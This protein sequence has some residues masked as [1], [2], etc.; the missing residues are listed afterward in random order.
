MK[1]ILLIAG[2]EETF[3]KTKE[4]LRQHNYEISIAY[5]LEDAYLLMRTNVYHLVIADD[6]VTGGDSKM[7]LQKI[8]HYQHL[9]IIIITDTN[10]VQSAIDIIKLGAFDYMV[11]PVLPD[12]ILAIIEDA[13]NNNNKADI[14]NEPAGLPEEYIIGCS[15]A[16]NE[17]MQ[18][19][20]LVAPTNYSVI[21]HG[22]SGSGKEAIAYEIHKQSNRKNYPF[23]AVDCGAISG[24]LAGSELFGHD[25]GSFTGAITDK[26]GSFELAD[27]GTLFL[28]E[29][30]NLSYQVQVLLLRV[31][32]EKVI[33]HVGAQTGKPVD[34]R[35][36]VASN[37]KLWEQCLKGKFREDLFHRFNEFSIEV[38]P[39][40]K[41]I[42]DIP[43]FIDAFLKSANISLNKKIE[44][45]QPEV[46]EL[47]LKYNWPGN[48]R[49]LKNVIRRAA[50]LAQHNSIA[51]TNLPDEIIYYNNLHKNP[52]D[53]I[54]QVAGL[55]KERLVNAMSLKNF[56]ID[57]EYELILKALKAHNYNKTQAAKALQ[58]DRKTLYNKLS[59]YKAAAKQKNN[60]QPLT[61]EEK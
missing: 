57:Y 47:L 14:L 5:N 50:L 60:E 22:E 58:I 8:A 23:I 41:R 38:P 17:V 37:E 48:L 30:T 45:C 7:L 44:R 31:I 49:E 24:E 21:I 51:V 61:N 12:D 13:L 43:L 39:L 1:S 29:V 11:K 52:A 15:D 25:K 26:T 36:I 19:V 2:D 28:D 4:Y 59:V 32:Q 20:A 10:S 27:K 3:L 40:R 33:K 54:V 16:I 53:T 6:N 9:P 56:S 42:K 55:R 18:Q 34:V 46:M 35:I